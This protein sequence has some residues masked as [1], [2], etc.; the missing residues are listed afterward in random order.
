MT[1]SSSNDKVTMTKAGRTKNSSSTPPS[2]SGRLAEERLP[3]AVDFSEGGWATDAA[4]SLVGLLFFVSA[5]LFYPDDHFLYM[6]LGTCLA[7]L[8]GGLA[9]RFYPNRAADGVGHRGFY[10]SMTLG[11]SG[12]CLRYGLG[13]GLDAVF[14]YIAAVNAIYLLVSGCYVVYKMEHTTDLIDSA[15]GLSF[16]PDRVFGA[17]EAF[18]SVMEVVASIYYVVSEVGFDGAPSE[19]TWLLYSAVAANLLGWAAVYLFAF[20]YLA[21]KIDYDPSLMQRIFHFAMIVMLWSI[22]AAVRSD[23]GP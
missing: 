19:S 15:E 16:V 21:L 3:E 11:Y 23:V 4:T 20:L 6:H 1:T 2:S 18:C 9:H 14:G 17:G 12:N 13:W 8:F 5:L 7:H 10:I 22:D